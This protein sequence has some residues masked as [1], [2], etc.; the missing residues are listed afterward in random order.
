M[1][2]VIV[3]IAWLLDTYVWLPLVRPLLARSYGWP[4]VR[5]D[6][7]IPGTAAAFAAGVVFILLFAL[8]FLG[9]SAE[10]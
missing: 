2:A 10:Y 5:E 4:E 7:R 1:L 8:P 3:F 6:E 9:V